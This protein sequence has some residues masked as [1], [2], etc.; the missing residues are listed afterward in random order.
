MKMRMLANALDNTKR[1]VPC[2]S[3]VALYTTLYKSLVSQLD[4]VLASDPVSGTSN[5]FDDT[6][7]TG[8]FDPVEGGLL[9]LSNWLD[10][11]TGALDV[12]S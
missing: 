11:E 3:W 7:L 1:A 12:P 4:Q 9:D 10:V 5:D 8:W 2:T 6:A